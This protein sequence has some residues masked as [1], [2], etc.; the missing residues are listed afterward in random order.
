MQQNIC[1]QS[2][3]YPAIVYKN[4]NYD[5]QYKLLA[6]Y[7]YN[8]EAVGEGVRLV[9]MPMII[10]VFNEQGLSCRGDE[11]FNA[12][13]LRV[14]RSSFGIFFYI[15]KLARTFLVGICKVAE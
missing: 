14:I 12:N 2:I 9:Y 10:A 1:H 3:F 13:K 7:K 8:I 6:D 11:K 4:K 5:T 15:L